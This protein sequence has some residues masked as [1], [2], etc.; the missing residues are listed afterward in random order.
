MEA[1]KQKASPAPLWVTAIKQ[2]DDEFIEVV[3]HFGGIGSKYHLTATFGIEAAK[4]L[5]IGTKLLLDI[6]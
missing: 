3:A 6:G 4:E 2:L 5:R 1:N